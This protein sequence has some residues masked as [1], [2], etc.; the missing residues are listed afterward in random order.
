MNTLTE[1][2]IFISILVTLDAL[3][4]F[5]LKSDQGDSHG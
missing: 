5:S 4:V 2:T 3:T 1:V